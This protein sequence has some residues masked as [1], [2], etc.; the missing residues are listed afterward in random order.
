[1]LG[2]I[3]LYLNIRTTFLGC[4]VPCKVQIIDGQI[5]VC[6]K[7]HTVYPGIYQYRGISGIYR[8]NFK[9]ESKLKPES[10]PR[11][12]PDHFRGVK[13]ISAHLPLFGPVIGVAGAA[14]DIGVIGDGGA[15]MPSDGLME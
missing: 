3:E 10:K 4:A 15:A 12:L 1:M 5:L 6:A 7:T 2:I 14:V 11:I 8:T 9:P 13:V